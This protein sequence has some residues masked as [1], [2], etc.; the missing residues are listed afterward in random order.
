MNQPPNFQPQIRSRTTVNRGGFEQ[1]GVKLH[2][3][4]TLNIFTKVTNKANLANCC[5]F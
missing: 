5:G 2:R 3:A 4:K 1:G